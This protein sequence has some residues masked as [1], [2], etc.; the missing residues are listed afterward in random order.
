MKMS[1][2]TKEKMANQ[3]KGRVK[4]YFNA[5]GIGSKV[6]LMTE[7]SARNPEWAYV[8][9]YHEYEG[10]YYYVLGN[11]QGGIFLGKVVYDGCA[12]VIKLTKT[13]KKYQ[14]NKTVFDGWIREVK[15]KRARDIRDFYESHLQ[16]Y[17]VKKTSFVNPN[18]YVA[19]VDEKGKKDLLRLI[20]KKEF[21]GKYYFVL[22]RSKNDFVVTKLVWADGYIRAALLSEKELAE[23]KDEFNIW[24]YEAKKKGEKKDIYG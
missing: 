7:C 9:Q 3:R 15:N 18:E 2:E 13:S 10:E 17:H 19:L 14:K 11:A 24:L 23:H 20:L 22:E 8:L 6:Y 16:T 5:Y 4:A 1:Y 21:D 12:G